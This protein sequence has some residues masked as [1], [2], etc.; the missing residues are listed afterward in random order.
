[1]R[2]DADDV[3]AP[4][5]IEE[6]LAVLNTDPGAA[7]AYSDGA[8]FGAASGAFP[9]LDFNLNDLAEG[10]HVTC[11]A[12]IRRCAFEA[13]GGYDLSMARLRCEDWDLWLRFAERELRGVRIPRSLWYY[14]RHTAPSR[15]IPDLLTM[16]GLRR[17][18]ELI[19]HL[20]D[21]HPRTFAPRLL[22]RRLVRLPRR[23]LH[24][25]LSLRHAGLLVA[26]YA[27]MLLRLRPRNSQCG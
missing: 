2:L 24:S 23:L 1:M 4:T 12:L 3:L 18:L 19:A 25:D 11:L 26:F 9:L 6:M 15:N 8:Y 17:E 22:L 20:Q 27:V 5:Y 21:N 7:F 16:A 14:R 10:A 13:V